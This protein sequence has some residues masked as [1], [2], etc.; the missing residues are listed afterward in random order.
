[1]LPK[2]F[3]GLA[4]ELVKFGTVGL[5]N[6]GLDY[7]VLNLLLAIG[8]LKAKVVAT[9][10]ATTASYLMNRKW[11]FGNR[12][13]TGIRREYAL[14]F[15]LNLVGMVIQ[16]A[17]LGVAKYG[18]GFHE[19][20]GG[21]DRLALNI[22]NAIGIGVAMVFRFWAYRTFVFKAPELEPAE[23]AETVQSEVSADVIADVEAIE[24]ALSDVALTELHAVAA[25]A[26]RSAVDAE[27]D[28]L[29]AE[30]DAELEARD[31]R[32]RIVD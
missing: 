23:T 4:D 6:T 24:V 19:H 27:F 26:Q 7:L 22:A 13:R 20:G 5:I 1:M 29:T 32:A 8:P 17:V 10:I 21:D 28:E 11:T 16:L 18:L 3:R 31:E 2:R 25:P 30:L 9:I 15:G 14:F 12:S